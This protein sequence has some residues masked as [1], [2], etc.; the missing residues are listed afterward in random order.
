MVSSLSVLRVVLLPAKVKSAGVT[1][2]CLATNSSVKGSS[3]RNS[4]AE[5]FNSLLACREASNPCKVNS[6]G[7][8]SNSLFLDQSYRYLQE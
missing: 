1:V 2:S 5:L 3:V 7:R 4:A 8:V 6:P